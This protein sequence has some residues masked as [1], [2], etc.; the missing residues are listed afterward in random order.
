MALEVFKKIRNVP[1][2]ADLGPHTDD[3]MEH[4]TVLKSFF[5]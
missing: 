5:F 4:S 2:D 3:G 1:N